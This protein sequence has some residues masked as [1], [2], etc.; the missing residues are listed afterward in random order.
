MANV[1]MDET[2]FY[3]YMINNNSTSTMLNAL[4]GNSS[5]DSSYGNMAGIL[6]ALQ[7]SGSWG[8]GGISDVSTLLGGIDGELSGLSSLNNNFANVLAAYTGNS[9]SQL[10][11]VVDQLQQVLQETS[12]TESQTK[13]YQTIQEIYTTLAQMYSGKADTV[14]NST[15]QSTASTTKQAENQTT[16]SQSFTSE[17]DFENIT[18]EMDQVMEDAFTEIIL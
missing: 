1:S 2:L 10:S 16:S 7:S 3:Q 11:G 6:S 13:S 18:K 8:T 4:S 15:A 5:D 9:Q 17:T 14:Q 12:E